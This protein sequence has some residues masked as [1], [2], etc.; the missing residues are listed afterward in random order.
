MSIKKVWIEDGC[1]ACNL[2]ET[3][4]PEVFVIEDGATVKAN[5]D[6]SKYET[7]IKEAAA[8][9]PVQVIKFIEK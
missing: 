8:S 3:I 6:Y 1:I 2:S 9:C 7:E 4:C 5:V